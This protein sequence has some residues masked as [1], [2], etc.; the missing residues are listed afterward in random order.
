MPSASLQSFCASARDPARVRQI[1][2]DE[3][4]VIISQALPPTI[5][6]PTADYLAAALGQISDLLAAYGIAPN[7]PDRGAQVERLLVSRGAEMPAEDRHVLRGHFPLSVRLGEEL[8]GIPLHLAD[9]PFLYDILAAKRLF[10]HIPPTARF[11]LPGNVQAAVPAHQD[12]SYNRHLGAF[13]VVWVPLVDI[14]GACGGMAAYPRSHGRGELLKGASAAAADTWLP[15]INTSKLERVELQPLAPGDVVV[16]SNET[17]HESMPNRSARTR[18]SIDFRF[19][20]DN[21]RSSK[22]FLDLAQRRI[23]PP[24]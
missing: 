19:F 2:A 6:G 4:L 10:M 1:F 20:G 16:M 15:G 11:V 21:S 13:C 5:C 23:V 17:V 14:D 22:H 9:H 7:A 3:G 8:W 12:I 18:L 24:A